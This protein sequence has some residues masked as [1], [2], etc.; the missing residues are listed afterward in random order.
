LG[1]ISNGYVKSA[2]FF[3]DTLYVS[4]NFSYL[5][6]QNINFVAKR[7]AGNYH[8]TC[9]ASI[10]TIVDVKELK[11]NIAFSIYP[12]PTNST[13]TIIDEQNQLQN[14]TLLITNTLGEVVLSQGFASQIDLSTFA[15][16]MYYITVQDG[17]IKKTVKVVKQ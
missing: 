8:D 12:N 1:G 10:P 2:T 15:N 7:L 17:S 6:N 4:G 3:R 16:G 9:G 11:N 5:G 14:S 13:L